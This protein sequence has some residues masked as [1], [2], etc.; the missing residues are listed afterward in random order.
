MNLL[1]PS[2][3]A[4][5]FELNGYT[6]THTVPALTPLVDLLREG[7]GVTSVRT[8]CRIGRCGACN[9]LVDG[10]ATPACLVTAWQVNGHRVETVEG[11]GTD[12]DFL[13]VREALALESAL[14]CGYCTPGFVLSLVT[15]LREQRRGHAVDLTE[16]LVG[17]LCRCTG[18]GGLKRA[19]ERHL[20]TPP[21]AGAS[22]GA[23][24]H[25]RISGERE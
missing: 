7:E 8:G 2:A 24:D 21:L 4:I 20:S 5:T 15:G 17:N 14:Q 25:Q 9:V 18:Y 19:V 22:N 6:V 1:E 23:E 16:A 13:R 11:L 12:P 3:E 10:E